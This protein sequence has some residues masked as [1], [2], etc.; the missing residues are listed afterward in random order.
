MLKGTE[1]QLSPRKQL[2]YFALVFIGIFVACNVMGIILLEVLYPSGL[3]HALSESDFTV[4]G[5]AS[6]LYLLQ[7]VTMTLPIFLAPLFFARVTVK[8]TAAYLKP[9]FQFHWLLLIV[10]FFTMMTSA[11]VIEGL[12]NIN[13][14]MVLPKWL[15][16]LENWMKSSERQAEMMTNAILKMDTVA[17]MLKNVL[18]VGLLTAIA[19]EFMFRGVLQTI[20]LR[21]T[22]NTHAAVWITAA[23]F[24]AFHMEFYGF[25]PRLLLGGLF[26][27]FVVWS[28]SIWPG[29]WAHFINNATAVVVTYL[30]QQKKIAI[31]PDDTH[32]F[33]YGGYIFSAII[34]II[35]LL[36]YKSIASGKKQ[37]AIINGEELG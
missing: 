19:E 16:W 30:Y 5:T 21:I 1:N 7:I 37:P 13:Q 34:I 11:P 10:V 3:V 24:S 22:K 12:S 25:L 4:P 17:D 29:V 32:T 15:N 27:Y 35:L 18:L 6:A 28:G 36:V 14:Q 9:E 31:N 33:T 20:M 26:G 2:L 8:N 23:I